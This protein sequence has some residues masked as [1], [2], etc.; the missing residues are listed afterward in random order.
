MTSVWAGT[1]SL[2]GDADKYIFYGSPISSCIQILKGAL[3]Y[4]ILY[5]LKTSDNI[6]QKTN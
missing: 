5:V 1:N 3:A 6:K 2:K 4:A